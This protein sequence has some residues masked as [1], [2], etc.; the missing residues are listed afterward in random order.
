LAPGAPSPGS[1]FDRQIFLYDR[2]N[3][4]TTPVS[5]DSLGSGADDASFQPSCSGDGR[6]VI[7]ISQ[8]YLHDRR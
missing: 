4:R 2:E 8:V 6:L 1:P 5:V 7:G 3:R